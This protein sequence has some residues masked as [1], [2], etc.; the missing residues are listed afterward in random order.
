MLAPAS[1][2]DMGLSI[3]LTKVNKTD[4]HYRNKSILMP[5]PIA[6]L[7]SRSENFNGLIDNF[8][9][10]AKLLVAKLKMV[11]VNVVRPLTVTTCRAS[12]I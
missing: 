4:D 5:D 1:G 10:P 3:R 2:R 8:S 9:P 7:W 12:E 6:V 11:R